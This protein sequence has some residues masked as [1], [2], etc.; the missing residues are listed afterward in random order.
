MNASKHARVRALLQ[1]WRRVAVVHGR[2]QW[3]QF[4]RSGACDARLKSRTGYDRVGAAYGQM[5]RHQVVGVLESFLSNRQNEFRDLVN[6]SGV[7]ATVRH[8]LHFINRWK[9]WHTLAVPLT[10]KDGT[11]IPE[12]VRRLARAIFRS[13]MAHHRRPALNRLNMII[14]QRMVSVMPARTAT[15]FPL[16]A[17]LSTLEKGVRVELPLQ[18]YEH[19]TLRA[20][21]RALTV[22]VNQRPDGSFGVGILTDVTNAF[23]ASRA[24]YQPRCEAIALDLGLNTLFATNEGDLLGRGWR[25]KLEHYDRR[26]TGLAKYLQQRG[27]KPNRHARYRARVAALRGCLTSEVNRILNRLVTTKAPAELVLERLDFRAP[28][29]SKRLNRLL[30][31]MGRGIIEAKLKDLEERLGIKTTKALAAYSSQTDSACGYVDRANRS[32]QA[33]FAC[34]WCGHR[35]HADVN[36]ARNLLQRRSLEDTGSG[37]AIRDALLDKLVRQHVE[38]YHRPR[39]RSADPRLSNPYFRSW[40]ATAKSIGPFS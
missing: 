8:Q 15:H 1:A 4:Y 38:R 2:E 20:G 5:I 33:L 3:K 12:D 7:D 19:H 11:V 16:W 13:V 34:R 40:A 23:E 21:T 28:G 36:A 9:A 10:M 14:D 39:G 22:Q 35:K 27:S 17:R 32:T 30:S 24:A 18:T 25:A 29:L 31:N 6:R 37:R 26:I